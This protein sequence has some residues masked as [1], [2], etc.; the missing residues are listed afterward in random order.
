MFELEE[1]QIAKNDFNEL[2][3]KSNQAV[4]KSR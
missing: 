1:K 2:E 3:E 4:K